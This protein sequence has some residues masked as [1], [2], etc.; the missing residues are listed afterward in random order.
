M[1][2]PRDVS[3]RFTCDYTV[4]CRKSPSGHK[5]EK[6]APHQMNFPSLDVGSE[7]T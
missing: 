4:I 2:F 1:G 3:V 5:T 7:G 6:F